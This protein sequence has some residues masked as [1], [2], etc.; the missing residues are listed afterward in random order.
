MQIRNY[1]N[2]KDKDQVIKLWNK[3]FPI[4]SP[5]NDPLTS[6]NRKLAVDDNLFFVAE[7]SEKNVI[8]TI[9]AGYDGHRGWIY[10]L[11]VKPELRNQNIGSLMVKHAE[12]KLESLGCPRINLMGK[13]GNQGV[14]SF[15]Q[16]LGYVDDPV[17]V[18]SK[19]LYEDDPYE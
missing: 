14:F 9:I 18:L 2:S 6:I 15:Y 10:Y 12:K 1:D 8:G 19:R 17:V 4:Y 5:H 7:S 16:K 3:V 11:A 13:I